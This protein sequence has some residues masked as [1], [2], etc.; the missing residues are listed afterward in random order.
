MAHWCAKGPLTACVVL[1]YGSRVWRA[2]L[3]A[4]SEGALP[5]GFEGSGNATY[6]TAGTAN[7]GCQHA[8]NEGY[9]AGSCKTVDAQG[10]VYAVFMHYP[11]Q[12]DATHARTLYLTTPVVRQRSIPLGF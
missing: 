3:P 9:G 6:Y 11:E 5:G 10:V 12:D 1:Q 7:S 4:G 2:A 8:P